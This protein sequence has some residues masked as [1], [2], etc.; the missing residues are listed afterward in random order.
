ML[1]ITIGYNKSQV[2]TRTSV[3]EYSKTE[4]KFIYIYAYIYINI[5]HSK[6]TIYYIYGV[7]QFKKTKSPKTSLHY[8]SDIKV[9]SI[10]NYFLTCQFN[11]AT[12]NIMLNL[13]WTSFIPKYS[14]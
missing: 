3:I 1:Q 14:K 7:G 8:N 12:F 13:F 6:Y 4:H 5:H 10:H 9:L 11:K 2:S